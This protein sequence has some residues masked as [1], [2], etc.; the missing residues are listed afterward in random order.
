MEPDVVYCYCKPG[1]GVWDAFLLIMVV[2][3]GPLT[4]RDLLV[5]LPFSF[6]ISH[7][8]KPSARPDFSP[9]FD[10]FSHHSLSTLKTAYIMKIPEDQQFQRR[11]ANTRTSPSGTS[12]QI[13]ETTFSAFLMFDVNMNCSLSSWLAS[14]WFHALCCCHIGLDDCV[15]DAGYKRSVLNIYLLTLCYTQPCE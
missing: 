10:R 9:L 11:S 2:K 6:G 5:S 8:K 13:I 12:K 15:N 7:Q 3:N 14:T 1:C 4:Y